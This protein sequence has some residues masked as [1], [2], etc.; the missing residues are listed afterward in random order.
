MGSFEW[1]ELQTLT[2]DIAHARG[3]LAT[4]RKNKDIRRART[5]EEE[6]AAAEGRREHLLA[7][8]TT[9]LVGAPPG[10]LATQGIEGAEP[11][12]SVADMVDAVHCEPEEERQPLELVDPVVASGEPPPAVTAPTDSAE[13]GNIVWEQLT[14]NDI[15]RAR[16][17]L[18][19][20]RAE[21]LARHAEELKGLDA[22]QSQIETLEQ[23]IAAFAT[24]FNLAPAADIVQL[25]DQRGLRHQGRG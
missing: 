24:K 11:E 20:R 16:N 12:Q 9:N 3:R 23:A 7:H 25:D 17:E 14:P 8:I 13:G 22:D 2:S 21:L 1:M 10:A 5:L 18:G 19:V 6:I 4:A 15:E